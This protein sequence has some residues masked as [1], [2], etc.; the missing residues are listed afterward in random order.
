MHAYMRRSWRRPGP[1]RPPAHQPASRHAGIHMHMPTGRTSFFASRSAFASISSFATPS[2]WFP[3]ATISAVNPSCARNHSGSRG[4]GESGSDQGAK[5]VSDFCTSAHAR[6]HACMHACMHAAM[7]KTAR[8]A[9]PT[10]NQPPRRYTYAPAHETHLVC[11]IQVRLR[12]DQQ[13]RRA[14]GFLLCGNHQRRRSILRTQ[15]RRQSRW[16]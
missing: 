2:P 13:L 15:S 1:A 14:V 7:M 6:T 10:T 3:T 12:L 8:P 16:W 9:R 5:G 4:G 11:R